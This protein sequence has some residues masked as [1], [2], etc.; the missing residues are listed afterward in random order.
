MA[1]HTSQMGSIDLIPRITKPRNG[2]IDPIRRSNDPQ[3]GSR[4]TYKRGPLDPSGGP[5]R[6][7][8]QVPSWRSP[9]PSG[10]PPGEPLPH[11]RKC[12]SRVLW[13]PPGR[14]HIGHLPCKNLIG[15]LLGRFGAKI[16]GIPVRSI[17]CAFPTMFFLY[18]RVPVR[19]GL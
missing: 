8:L 10:D 6:R 12:G 2:S 7:D 9:D 15:R 3:N 19:E 16:P 5:V 11:P 17:K 18:G 13:V 14:Y 4:G 1:L